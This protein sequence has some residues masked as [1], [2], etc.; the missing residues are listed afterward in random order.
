MAWTTEAILA[1]LRT[2]LPHAPEGFVLEHDGLRLV[3]GDGAVSGAVL[4]A[5]VVAASSGSAAAAAAA[6]RDPSKG[7]PAPAESSGPSPSVPDGGVV[8]HAPT[9]GH[10][11]HRPDPSSPPFVTPG[12]TVEV[13]A[14]LGLIEVM[15]MFN[16]VPAPVAGR[17]HAVLVEDGAFVE[18]GQPLLVILPDDIEATPAAGS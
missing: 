8:V 5:P 9:V 18:H 1:L 12:A 10:Y 6:D 17:V 2:V 13:G 16:A 3:I 15:K 14:T 4:T 7:V 11:Y